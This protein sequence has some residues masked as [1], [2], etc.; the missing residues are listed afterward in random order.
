M[1]VTKQLMDPVIGGKNT[2]EVNGVHQLFGYQHSSKYHLLFLPGERNS[3][4]F[5]NW[6]NSRL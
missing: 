5:G 4:M 2:T 1:S 3:Y 6:N